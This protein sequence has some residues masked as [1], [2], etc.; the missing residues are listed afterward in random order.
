M[1]NKYIEYHFVWLRWPICSVQATSA[2]FFQHYFVSIDVKWESDDSGEKSSTRYS[3]ND[4]QLLYYTTTKVRNGS[5]RLCGDKQGGHIQEC[6][7][8]QSV[9]WTKYRREKKLVG[10]CVY[11]LL[12]RM[13][14][15]SCIES[16]SI[17]DEYDYKTYYRRYIKNYVLNTVWLGN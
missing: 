6:E 12:A 13:F 8:R 11:F 9:K 2:L 4:E 16:S 14:F 1:G 3:F 10:M 5:T 15:F 17:F 7:R